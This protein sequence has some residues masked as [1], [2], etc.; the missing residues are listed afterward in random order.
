MKHAKR[1]GQQR[2]RRRIRVRNALKEHM[3]RPRLCVFRSLKHIY[4][5]VINDSTGRTIVSASTVDKELRQAVAYGGNKNAAAA[6]GRAIAQRAVAAGVVKAAFDRREYMYHGRVAAL[7][8]AAR[9]AGL[10]LGAK[11]EVEVKPEPEAKGKKGAKEKGA[12][13]EKPAKK[14][15]SRP[16]RRRNSR[17]L[18][19]PGIPGRFDQWLQKHRVAAS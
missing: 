17:D 1:I 3:T 15:R 13:K 8:D 14:K 18:N 7:A 2:M 4:A 10:D 9:D 19:Q 11:P 6:V 5:Q 16:K 12:A